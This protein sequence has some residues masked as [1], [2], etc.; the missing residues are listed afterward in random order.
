VLVANLDQWFVKFKVTA[1][2]GKVPGQGRLNPANGQTLFTPET[3]GAIKEAKK[4]AQFI[5]DALSLE[6]IY[7]PAEAPSYTQLAIVPL[8]EGNAI[9]TQ[10]IPCQG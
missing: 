4:K 8:C 9:K 7:Q 5:L 2:K 10:V 3:K 1:S 6:A